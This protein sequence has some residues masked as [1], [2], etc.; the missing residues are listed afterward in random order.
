MRL[1]L[2]FVLVVALQTSWPAS[3]TPGLA[4][5]AHDNEFL[6]RNARW[7][8]MESKSNLLYSLSQP[9]APYDV[10]IVRPHDRETALRI[11]VMKGDQELYAWWGHAGTVFSIRE[12][13]LY[14]VQF[15]RIS[16]GAGLVAVDLLTKKELWRS[17]LRG[18]GQPAHS[19]YSNAVNLIA[20]NSI[21]WVYGNETAGRYVE[22][23]NAETGET[24]AN[25]VF[26]EPK[27]AENKRSRD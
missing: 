26:E 25:K 21:V 14:Y 5:P 24:L 23:T 18:V 1:S 2:A 4:A 6:E 11:K 10:V 19:Y 3:G 13:R 12:D 16:P 17:T 27:A 8:W 20:G 9:S 15:D 22:Y 7:L